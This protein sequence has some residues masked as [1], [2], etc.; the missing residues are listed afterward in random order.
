MVKV[1]DRVKV[2][3]EFNPRSPLGVVGLQGTVVRTHP[4]GPYPLDV[5]LD[6]YD[7]DT[8]FDP[9]ELEVLE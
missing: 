8:L 5:R 2:V 1:G 6:N 4:S 7:Y 3:K 9:C